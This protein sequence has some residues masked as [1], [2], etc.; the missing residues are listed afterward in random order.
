MLAPRFTH[1]L[2]HG[3]AAAA[4]FTVRKATLTA[5]TL[6]ACTPRFPRLV[7]VPTVRPEPENRWQL[8]V[9]YRP[10]T[11]AFA[12][13]L[14]L[15]YIPRVRLSRSRV[16][17]RVWAPARKGRANT[18]RW[19]S[20]LNRLLC[21]FRM[22]LVMIRL[23]TL[24]LAFSRLPL[25]ILTPIR[26]PAVLVILMVNRLTEIK[27]G[28]FLGR[29]RFMAT[30]KLFRDVNPLLLVVVVSVVASADVVLEVVGADVLEL[31]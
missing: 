25:Q 24:P 1:R 8:F 29:V 11:I 17:I 27:W 3:T 14:V 15:V 13:F 26:L 20:K 9:L 19:G 2:E 31:L 22:A 23:S 7:G 10:T 21:T 4:V 12:L 18:S 5:P 16:A 30:A 28:P 6:P